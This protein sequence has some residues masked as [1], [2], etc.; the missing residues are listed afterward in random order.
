[1]RVGPF[2]LLLTLLRLAVAAAAPLSADEAYYRLWSHA[3]APGYLDHPPMVA[4]WIWLGTHIAGDTCLGI[5]LLAPLAAALGTLLLLQ[6]ARDLAQ[7]DAAARRAAILLNATLTLNA[8][9]VLMTPDTPQLLFWTASLAALA[10][11]QRS[12]QSGWF[13]AA[14]A[15]AGLALAS[16]YSAALL[17]PCSLVW[18]LAVPGLRPWLRRWQ[19]YAGA[20]LALAIFAP[21]LAWNAAHHWV[22]FAKQG[23]R[24]GAWHPAAAASHIAEL[25]AG[26]IGL[27]T[28]AVFLVLCAGI[29]RL[30]PRWRRPDCALPV[31]FTVLP[32]LVFVQH[33]VG[34]RVQANWPG[35][36]YPGAALAAGLAAPPL[37]RAAAATGYALAA[38]VFTQAAAAPFAL[39][40]KLDFTL[41]RLAGWPG[42]A[43][44]VQQ[45]AA[46]RHATAILADE[47]ALAAELAFHAGPLPVYGAEPRWALFDLPQQCPA[48]PA[49]LVR[50]DRR[51]FPPGPHPARLASVTRGRGGIVAETYGIYVVDGGLATACAR[52]TDQA[53]R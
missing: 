18:L 36:L 7:D 37:W 23:G 24:E 11:V 12:G 19:P 30:A 50:S 8:G 35:I 34:D 25:I 3:L 44:A 27:A 20:A 1:M 14:G 40:R 29:W 6:A 5:R 26:Q 53:S 21:V 51:A 41:I 4:L 33:A 10:R 48:G 43:A 15:A 39:P 13:L 17:A 31:I 16:K 49:L 2:L 42:L 45:Q 28:P 46:A 22:S 52:L 38:L 32:L 9:A 47:Y